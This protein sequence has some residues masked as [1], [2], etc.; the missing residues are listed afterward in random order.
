[1]KELLDAGVHFGPPDVG[2]EPEDEEYILRRTKTGIPLSILRNPQDVRCKRARSSSELSG[3]AETF[4][5]WAPS[6]Q[7]Q[8]TVAEYGEALRCVFRDSQPTGWVGTL[9]NWATLPKSSNS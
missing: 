9:T 1:M 5:L 6:G 4:F 8:E 2:W 3:K 7:A